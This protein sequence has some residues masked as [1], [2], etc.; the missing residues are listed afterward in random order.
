MSGERSEEQLRRRAFRLEYFTVAWDVVEGAI[1]ITAGLIAGSIALLGF[2]IDS[3][4]EVFAASVVIWQ[5]RAPT[6]DGRRELA[7]RLIALTFFALAAYV[8]F[9]SVS[10]LVANEEPDASLVG[11]VLNAVA[12]P[13]M[14]VVAHLKRTTGEA[15]GNDVLVADAGETRLSN[16]L[17]LT[18]LA[19]LALNAA[20]G[21]WWADPVAA[22]VVAGFAAWSGSA[23]W[24]EARD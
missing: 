23:A 8:A 13:I 1:A 21:W 6:R 3:S 9:E 24:R 5:L 11:I 22:L 7:L 15:L 20:L 4:I 16:Y 2:G 17:S 18:V 12:L 10:V 19:G 14:A